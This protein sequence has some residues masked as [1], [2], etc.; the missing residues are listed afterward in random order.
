M[1]HASR[2]QNT[3]WQTTFCEATACLKLV[4]ALR[5]QVTAKTFSHGR[6]QRLCEPYD[7]AVFRFDRQEF[8]SVTLRT[9]GVV[10]ERR[11]T[12]K[13][14]RESQLQ[15]ESPPALTHILRRVI[16]L[17]TRL[18]HLRDYAEDCV[19]KACISNDKVRGNR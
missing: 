9:L 15:C 3:C 12:A 6:S 11:V 19:E 18:R 17:L 13:V 2:A 10:T 7:K 4:T 16:Q 14:S 8:S 1:S 5:R